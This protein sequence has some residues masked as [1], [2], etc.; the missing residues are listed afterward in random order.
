MLE[1][2]LCFDAEVLVD[3]FG[4]ELFGGLVEEED[5]ILS[6]GE[7]DFFAVLSHF[8]CGGAAVEFFGGVD[9]LF[10]AGGDGGIGEGN[11]KG[12]VGGPEERDVALDVFGGFFVAEIGEHDDQGAFAVACRKEAK[13]FAV[14]G[15]VGERFEVVEDFED[16]SKV[17]I[18]S[19]G[20]DEVF[21]AMAEQ[22]QAKPIVEALGHVEQEHGGFDGGVDF[23]LVSDLASHGT[24]KIKNDHHILAAF[25]LVDLGDGF[26]PFGG[27][28]PIDVAVFVVLGVFAEAFEFGASSL[29]SKDSHAALGHL[30]GASEKVVFFEGG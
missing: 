12:K 29:S 13:H 27:G 24:A 19:V 11:A 18:S 4:G 7:D 10:D 23:S 5:A 20:R 15:I 3:G 26:A 2:L 6:E 1:E 17:L 25:G 30:M 28:F 21:G 9:G 8:E 22:Q 16:A 14:L